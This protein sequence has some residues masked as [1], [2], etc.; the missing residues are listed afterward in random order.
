MQRNSNAKEERKKRKA[1]GERRKKTESAPRAPPIHTL[2]E[3]RAKW[4]KR[5][6]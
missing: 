1:L 3:N 5:K 6:L 4:A 2:S